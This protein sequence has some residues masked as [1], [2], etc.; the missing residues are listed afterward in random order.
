[1]GG[2]AKS[3]PSDCTATA[4][5]DDGREIE[6]ECIVEGEKGSAKAKAAPK[7]INDEMAWLKDTRWLWNEWREVIFRADG[8]FLAP[9]ENCER[10]GNPQCKWSADEDKIYVTFGNAGMHTLTATPDQQEISG[11]RDSDG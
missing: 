8:S 10:P 2:A 4:R 5:Y 3:P 9:A 1:M 6:R 7:K 11:S